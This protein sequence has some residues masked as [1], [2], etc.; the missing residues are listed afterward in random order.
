MATYWSSDMAHYVQGS[1]QGIY[2][3]MRFDGDATGGTVRSASKRT[4]K[5]GYDYGLWYP[6][7]TIKMSK[8][9]GSYSNLLTA[10][11]AA[12]T[13]QA[14]CST[15]N[16]TC[17][18]T[19]ASGNSYERTDPNESHVW[20]YS[21]SGPIGILKLKYGPNS[22]STGQI[23]Y[24]GSPSKGRY[25]LYE[26]EWVLTFGCVRIYSGGWKM[27]LPYVYSGGWKQAIPYVY[28]GGWKICG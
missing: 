26:T 10:N 11:A 27:A 3:W 4:S 9:A 21:V 22:Y 17:Y 6:N 25:D 1:Q 19:N 12:P 23:L 13:H 15:L 16:T 14:Y 24:E 5:A 18:W 8:N 28:S 20:K 2:A 7:C